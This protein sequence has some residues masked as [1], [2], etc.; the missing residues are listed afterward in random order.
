MPAQA[1]AALRDAAGL[2]D[3]EAVATTDAER[4]RV[5]FVIGEFATLRDRG[6]IT[7]ARFEA[8]RRQL[9]GTR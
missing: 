4:R 1:E 6:T 8:E 7:Q 5:E 2:P 9:L 3:V